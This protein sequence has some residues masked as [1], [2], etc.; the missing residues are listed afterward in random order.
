MSA[1]LCGLGETMKQKS[2]L[3]IFICLTVALFACMII[4]NGIQTSQGKVSVEAVSYNFTDS[5][6][7]P[8]YLTGKLYKPVTATAANPAPA[9]LMLHGY[10]NDKETN[11]AYSIELS[12]RGVVVLS[13]DEYGHGWTT[14]GMKERGW[15]NHKVT[16]NYGEDSEEAGTY[17]KL[18]SGGAL[19]YK[20]MMNFSNL[21]FF[22]II[23]RS[24]NHAKCAA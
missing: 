8:Q 2:S 17:K 18:G 3:I 12:R 23:H 4:A 6:G 5:N 9:V 14:A 13:L 22:A 19:R 7:E 20:I 16:V 11:D 21:S 15:T 1:A 10:Q 24:F